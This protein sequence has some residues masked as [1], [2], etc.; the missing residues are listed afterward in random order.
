MPHPI[1]VKRWLYKADQDFG[2]SSASLTNG[3]DYYD[4]PCFFFQQAAEKYLKAYILRYS[5]R[6]EKTHDL[7]KLLEICKENDASFEEI[8]DA[9]SEL[10]TLYIE[11]RYADTGFKIYTREETLSA[12][13]AA[14]QIQEF[15]RKKLEVKREITTEEMKAAEEEADKQFREFGEQ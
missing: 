1:I 5:L 12:Q 15:V 13:E 6:F 8:E 9:A 3:Y 4:Q 11:P 2:F 14:R 7:L 10:N